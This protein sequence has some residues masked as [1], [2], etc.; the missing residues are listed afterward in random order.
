[1]FKTLKNAPKSKDFPWIARLDLEITKMQYG[2]SVIS[3]GGCGATIIANH[4]LLTGT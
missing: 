4:Y 2:R 3:H 1:M